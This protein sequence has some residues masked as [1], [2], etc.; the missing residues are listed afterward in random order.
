VGNVEPLRRLCRP[1]LWQDYDRFRIGAFAF[2]VSDGLQDSRDPVLDFNDEKGIEA[3]HSLG[4]TPWAK[5]TADVQYVNPAR[6]AL[7][8]A[9][10]T[11]LR[12]NVAF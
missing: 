5:L 1:G 6:G 8:P 12:L 9:L 11:A 7:E 2:N 3:W 10:I 4:L